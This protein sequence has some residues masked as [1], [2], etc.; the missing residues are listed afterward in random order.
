M[1]MRIFLSYS[2]H[3]LPKAQQL[4]KQLEADSFDVVYDLQA[5]VKGEPWRER[6]RELI[7]SAD[8]VLFLI[9]PS[10]VKSQV[11]DWEINEAELLSKRIFPVVIRPTDASDIP[12]R[13][14]RL[15]YTYLDTANDEQ[16][17][18]SKLLCALQ[19]DTSWVR[20]HTRLLH[21]AI[22]WNEAKRP[23]RLLLTG[24]DIDAAERWRDRPPQAMPVPSDLCT[25]FITMS[26]RRATAR[27]RAWIVGLFSVALAFLVL[28]AV[29]LMQRERA[30][31]QR[32]EAESGELSLRSDMKRAVAP[33]DSL[34]LAVA[35]YEKKPTSSAIG[36]IR[37]SVD[38]SA[39][40]QVRS[41]FRV[42]SFS[43]DGAY[44]AG[45]RKSGVIAVLDG[46]TLR[47]VVRLTEPVPGL[48]TVAISA[49]GRFLSGARRS[50]MLMVWDLKSGLNARIVELSHV[51]TDLKF[52]RTEAVIAAIGE[53]DI[54]FISLPD[55]RILST[56]R[57][58]V[59]HGSYV[60][61]SP[62]DAI[63]LAVGKENK[64]WLVDTVTGAELAV[65]DMTREAMALKPSLGGSDAGVLEQ[66]YFSEDGKS[67]ITTGGHWFWRKWDVS[68][69][70]KIADAESLIEGVGTHWVLL[71]SDGDT[72]VTEDGNSGRIAWWS[73][74]EKSLFQ[75]PEGSKH[76]NLIDVA[77]RS[78]DGKS[79]ATIGADQ[80]LMLWSTQEHRRLTTFHS[81]M[82]RAT[83]L[84]AFTPTSNRLITANK[85]G[86]LLQW[87]TASIVRVGRLPEPYRGLAQFS[88]SGQWLV[89]RGPKGAVAVWSIPRM[90]RAAEIDGRTTVKV[91]HAAI[92]ADGLRVAAAGEDGAVWLWDVAKK[93]ELKRH[94][95]QFVHVA[96]DPMG[97]FVAANE[98][99]G[100]VL[101]VRAAD[102]VA[103][104][105]T[106]FEQGLTNTVTFSADGSDYVVAGNDGTAV[107]AA[108]ATGRVVTSVSLKGNPCRR[109]AFGPD[110]RLLFTTH[111]DNVLRAWDLRTRMVVAEFRGHASGVQRIQ[112]VGEGALLLSSSD[113]RTT[114]LWMVG[115]GSLVRSFVSNKDR[116]LDA[117]LIANGAIMVSVDGEGYIY[118]QM[119]DACRNDAGLLAAARRR[120]QP[121]AALGF[122]SHR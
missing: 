40:L 28:A 54:S 79:I 38:A 105:D 6:L 90:E 47:E 109:A 29:A 76:D 5:I 106:T 93:L 75:D 122:L 32:L 31:D 7:Q 89:T 97:S 48:S 88:A 74:S 26:R 68:T 87:N 80:A 3:D 43:N 73:L 42:L 115:D 103:I 101:V 98:Y 49:K 60:D 58:S 17:E 102:G 45:L 4:T 59:F 24:Q 107:V 34:Q 113:D 66:G 63:A 77:A 37:R 111:D 96:F 92:S 61:F 83:K 33:E 10:S 104:S 116:V 20:E 69:G 112:A 14:Q 44:V 62:S 13:L 39:L 72:I 91:Q 81:P 57:K 82:L 36:A 1:L 56:V 19:E 94:S 86:E 8:T 30:I 11:C 119:C 85:D 84:A 117:A 16:A 118:K 67:V 41:G 114:R 52:G 46:E 99:G 9:S 23:V 35:A 71:L 22:R 2:R 18:F 65:L 95:G 53:H 78:A 50:T 120:L 70:R 51:V 27:Q 100:R 108:T 121:F 64:G 21:L 55:L 25:N 15:N 12:A 110:G